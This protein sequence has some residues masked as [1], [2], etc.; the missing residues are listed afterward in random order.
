MS[1]ERLRDA[2]QRVCDKLKALCGIAQIEGGN[3][4][5]LRTGD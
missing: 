3:V 1:S 2:A 5:R 4:A